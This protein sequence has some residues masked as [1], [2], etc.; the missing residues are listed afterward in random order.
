MTSD[1]DA[2]D[3]LCDGADADAT[4]R[5]AALAALADPDCRRVVAALDEPLTATAVAEECDLPRTTAYRKLDRLSEGG[6]VAEQGIARPDG[7]H[8]TA[9]VRDFTD[10]LVAFDEGSFAVEVRDEA[11]ET[12]E[13]ADERLA[14]YP[15]GVSEEL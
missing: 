1:D 11:D 15:T 9:Y 6:L 5:Q 7:H 13:S 8:A 12:G 10:V 14:R 4:G 3:R 2:G